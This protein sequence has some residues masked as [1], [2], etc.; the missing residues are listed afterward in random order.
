M[1]NPGIK[2]TRLLKINKTEVADDLVTKLRRRTSGTDNSDMN[3]PNRPLLYN[4][5]KDGVIWEGNPKSD[6]WEMMQATTD[7]TTKVK[8]ARQKDY[9]TYG[10]IPSNEERNGEK[11]LSGVTADTGGK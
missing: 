5:R 7:Q 8:W 10:K 9:D 2:H 4:E 11:S 1:R 6:K 3:V